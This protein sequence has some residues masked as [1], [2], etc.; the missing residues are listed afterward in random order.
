MP[1]ASF[2]RAVRLREKIEKL[3][4]ELNALLGVTGNGSR[5]GSKTDATRQT[6]QLSSSGRERIAQAQKQRWAKYHAAHPKPA[7][8]SKPSQRLSPNGRAKVS[9]AVK[10]RWER[11][12]AAKALGLKP[13]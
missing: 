8:Q 4:L 2:K 11:F 3:T 10:A 5:E 12:R 9:S 1:I 13:N 6:R 7:I